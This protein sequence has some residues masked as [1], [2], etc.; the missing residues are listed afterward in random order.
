MLLFIAFTLVMF[1]TTMG[2]SNGLN[3]TSA[4]DAKIVRGE[5][6]NLS[7][8]PDP[9]EGLNATVDPLPLVPNEWQPGPLKPYSAEDAE[10]N[11]MLES[12]VH[13][14]V[15]GAMGYASV[16]SVFAYHNQWW[17]KEWWAGPLLQL[18]SYGGMVVFFGYVV[19]QNKDDLQRLIG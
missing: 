8:E 13:S 2:V 16:V 6:Y 7:E 17:I 19:L 18:L 4:E 11:K 12:F 1:S 15:R 14:V 9:D 10:K 5:D 3:A